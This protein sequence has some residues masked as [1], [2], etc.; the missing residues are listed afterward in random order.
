MTSESEQFLIELA[1]SV[2][3]GSMGELHL[4]RSV[5]S[6]RRIGLKAEQEPQ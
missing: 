4:M 2:L 3:W 1:N 5:T 6:V